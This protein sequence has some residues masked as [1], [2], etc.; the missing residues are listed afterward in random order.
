LLTQSP[1]EWLVVSVDYFATHDNQ[2]QKGI[3]KGTALN[4][5]VGQSP[6]N[7]RKINKRQK[8][9]SFVPW[10]KSKLITNH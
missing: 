10:V 8:L 7:S 2:L 4:R 9:T 5:G 1:P 6:T 3:V